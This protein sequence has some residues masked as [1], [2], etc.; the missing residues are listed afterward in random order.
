M[1]SSA[2]AVPSLGLSARRKARI[3]GLLYLG[4]TIAGFANLSIENGIIVRGDA[5]ASMAHVMS[6][7]PLFR[8]GILA[9]VLGAAF[10]VGVTALL[11]EL[12]KPVSRTASLAAALFSLV[13]CAVGAGGAVLLLTPFLLLGGDVHAL[14]SFTP[15]Q[16]QALAMTAV[17]LEGQTY[18]VSMMFFGVYCTLIGILVFRSGFM[19][20][21]V[22]ALMVFAGVG[23]LTDTW[24][25]LLDPPLARAFATEWMIP[26]SIGEISLMLWLLFVGL[27]GPR[28]E[29]RAAMAAAAT[30]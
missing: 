10:Y 24:T 6:A 5:A 9:E 12:L 18:D 16:L 17:R 3:A 1:A 4:C 25:I 8:V 26:G 21:L 30:A 7:E 14:A 28:W 11:Y 29:S 15:L 20:R 23:W 19:P 22:G 2:H 27:N 13:G